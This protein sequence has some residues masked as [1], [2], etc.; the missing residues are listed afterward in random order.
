MT[1]LSRLASAAAVALMGSA[2]G[3]AGA[4]H[5]SSSVYIFGGTSPLAGAQSL[6]LNG[7][8]DVLQA[9]STGW[10]D[11]SGYHR[12]D[13]PNYIAAVCTV[14]LCQ[15]QLAAY[16]DYFVFDLSSVAGPITSAQ[17][18]LYNPGNPPG[19]KGAASAVYTNYD[20][21]IDIPD[22]VSEELG[23]GSIYA[24]LG[25]GVVYA[26]TKVSAANNGT[27]VLINLNGNAVASLNAAGGGQW[28]VGGA[29]SSVPEPAAW[30]MMLCGL[31]VLGA[32]TR[33]RRRT[34]LAT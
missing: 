6:I 23:A 21:L 10:Y 26:S 8:A 32:I 7:G 29:I 18:S 33:R 20:V 16:H 17:L 9:T 12:G 13:L 24:D 11:N 5:A 15:T 30:S 14:K 3:V 31:G 28:A 2:I 22:L 34:A 27:Q 4:A 1:Y 25:S 19:Y